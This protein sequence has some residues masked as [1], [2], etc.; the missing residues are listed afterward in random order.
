[1][2]EDDKAEKAVTISHAPMSSPT[3]I[4][5]SNEP[6]NVTAVSAPEDPSTELHRTV[7][8]GRGQTV[9]PVLIFL[10]RSTT[11]AHGATWNLISHKMSF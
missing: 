6:D 4:A 10:A 5:S 2:E 1:M 9:T 7:T 8:E 3:D 11:S